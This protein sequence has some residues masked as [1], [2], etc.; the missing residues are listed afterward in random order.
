MARW[1]TISAVSAAREPTTAK[2]TPQRPK[3]CTTRPGSEH[4]MTILNLKL[5]KEISKSSAACKGSSTAMSVLI[6]KSCTQSHPSF[7]GKLLQH[8]AREAP[9]PSFL[10]TLPQACC[11]LKDSMCRVQSRISVWPLFLSPTPQSPG[12]PLRNES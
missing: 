3:S 5:G 9:A 12:L 1:H 6:T 4:L 10:P 2:C 11:L 7:S 8:D